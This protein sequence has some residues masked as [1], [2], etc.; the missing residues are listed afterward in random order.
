MSRSKRFPLAPAAV[1]LAMQPPGFAQT[2]PSQYS[3]KTLLLLF[4][5]KQDGRE[6]TSPALRHTFQDGGRSGGDR[7]S[8]WGQDGCMCKFLL[9]TL[10]S[11]SPRCPSRGPVG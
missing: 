9:G 2:L 3:F 8:E 5:N 11:F 1:G 6:A 10:E 7:K 4:K